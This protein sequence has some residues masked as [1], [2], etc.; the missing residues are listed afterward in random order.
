MRELPE[1]KGWFLR[2]FGSEAAE[3]SRAADP[4]RTS[5]QKG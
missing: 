1:L 2:E 4:P 5:G 3:V